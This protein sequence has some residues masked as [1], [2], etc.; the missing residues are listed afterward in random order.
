MHATICDLITDLVQNSIEANAKEIT[1][2]VEETK[3]NLKVVIADNGKG[4]SAETLEKAKDPFWSDGL[5]H[6]HRKV[7]LGLPFLFQTSEMTGG[8]AQI[9]S[10]ESVGTTVAFNLDQTNVD[11]PMFGNFTTA[12]ITLLTYGFDGN[13]KIERSVDS[14][15]YTVSKQELQEALGDLNDLESLT[16]L[17]QFIET[18]EE[19]ING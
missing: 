5:K 13:L 7:G 19:E 14:K 10:E 6:K 9:E 15:S 3:T 17:K 18:N 11:L 2:N 4:M 12:M 1:L 16:L 8:N